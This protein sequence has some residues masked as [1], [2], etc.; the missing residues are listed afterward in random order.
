MERIVPKSSVYPT[1]KGVIAIIL[2][3]QFD[4]VAYQ[5]RLFSDT[6]SEKDGVVTNFTKVVESKCE[7][8]GLSIE[9]DKG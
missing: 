8:P 7:C 2:Y 9:H 1:A 6:A 4:F 3:Q 5:C